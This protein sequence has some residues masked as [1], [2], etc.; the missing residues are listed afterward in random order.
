MLEDIVKTAQHE[1]RRP[2][3]IPYGGSSAVGLMGYVEAMKELELFPEKFDW[4]V[5]PSSSGG[6]QAGMLLGA[7]GA[8]FTGKILGIC[9]EGNNRELHSTVASLMREGAELCG[10]P[11]VSEDTILVNDH[12]VG[13]GYGIMGTPEI[14]AIKLLALTEGL[15][16]D[17]VYTGRAAAGLIDLVRKG[18]FNKTDRVLF[19]HTGGTPALFAEPYLS[20]LQ[21]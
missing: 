9:I 5:I 8:G 18:F 16:L 17:P 13:G 14:E 19:W 11:P 3:K 20:L 2:Y 1:G 6:T 4:I 15:L 21:H 7:K 12:Y 10:L